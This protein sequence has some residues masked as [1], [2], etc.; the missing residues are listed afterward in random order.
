[1]PARNGRTPNAWHE[2]SEGKRVPEG[3]WMRCDGCQAT[4]VRKQVEQ[5]L[6]ICPECNHHF[7]LAAADRIAH[8]LDAE[9][10]EDARSLRDAKRVLRAAIDACLDGRSLKSREVMRALHHRQVGS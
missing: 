10:F 5:N 3:V 1:M 6:G 7:P 9:T 2:H 4:L 8:L